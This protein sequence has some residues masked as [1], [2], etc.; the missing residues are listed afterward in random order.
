MG[1]LYRNY[2]DQDIV[3]YAAEVNTMAQL[4]VKLG[5]RPAGGNYNNMRR[6]LQQLGV[7]CSH[8]GG[9]GWNA[10]K[11]LKDWSEYTKIES[12]KPHLIEERGHK[13]ERCLLEDWQGDKI[14]LEVDHSNGDRTDNSEQ[15]LKLLCCNCHALT[16]T[17]RGRNVSKAK[18]IVK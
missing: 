3:K 18:T 14:P 5:L 1:R 8:W 12:L 9:Q 10:G 7:D 15:N 16:S 13:C 17:W 2:T 11:R 4:F 6:K